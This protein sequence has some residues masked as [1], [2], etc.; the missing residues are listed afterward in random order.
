MVAMKT[1]DELTAYGKKILERGDDY[2]AVMNY[3]KRNSE[4]EDQIRLVIKRL[5]DMEKAGLI[6]QPEDPSDKVSVLDKIVGLIFI[7]GGFLLVA[8]LWQRGFIATLPLVL[9]AAGIAAITG[10]LKDYL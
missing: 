7:T 1:T 8:L 10:K 3:L 5:N 6:K 4:D 9:V 2:R